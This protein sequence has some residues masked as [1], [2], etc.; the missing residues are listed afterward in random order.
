MAGAAGF[1]PTN[2]KTKVMIKSIYK[3]DKLLLTLVNNDNSMRLYKMKLHFKFYKEIF[4]SI[5]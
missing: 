4:T 1:E 2:A 3:I 5:I